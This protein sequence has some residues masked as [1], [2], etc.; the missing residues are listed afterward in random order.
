[1]DNVILVATGTYVI[2][3]KVKELGEKI[4]L[5]EPRLYLFD[6][7]QHGVMKMPDSPDTITLNGYLFYYPISGD[8]LDMYVKHTSKIVLE[9]EIV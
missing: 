9:P 5:E 7:K 2:L 4:V 1:M 8:V 3:G 6:S